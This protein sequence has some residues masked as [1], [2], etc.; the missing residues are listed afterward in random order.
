MS[1][2]KLRERR[3]SDQYDEHLNP[4][5]ISESNAQIYVKQM[6]IQNNTNIQKQK[7]RFDEVDYNVIWRVDI[8]MFLLQFVV[9]LV[10]MGSWFTLALVRLPRVLVSVF[11]Q[12]Y[13]MKISAVER[14]MLFLKFEWISRFVTNVLYILLSLG[15]SLWLSGQF[16]DMFSGVFEHIRGRR[17]GHEEE[18]TYQVVGFR[19]VFMVLY[20]PIELVTMGVVYRHTHDLEFQIRLKS[21]L[22]TGGNAESHAAQYMLSGATEQT[23]RP[24][25]LV[26]SPRD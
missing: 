16:C 18:C 10:Y 2:R 25:Q 19:F 3:Q 11:A 22:M 23:A 5:E 12:K 20:Y 21:I 24:T 8:A 13:F 17:I 9:S 1:S 15:W 6:I 26:K 14:R 7:F 4:R